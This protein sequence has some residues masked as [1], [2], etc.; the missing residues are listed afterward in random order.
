MPLSPARCACA[1]GLGRGGPVR[2]SEQA[3]HGQAGRAVIHPFSHQ[4]ST[5]TRT[6]AVKRLVKP[7]GP[8]FCAWVRVG[9]RR[10]WYAP[11][12]RLPVRLDRDTQ[13]ALRSARRHRHSSSETFSPS[14]S[15]TFRSQFPDSRFR[16]SAD[17]E[18]DKAHQRSSST[19][20]D[21]AHTHTHAGPSRT[22]PTSTVCYCLRI[23]RSARQA[24]SCHIAR[25]A[26]FVVIP[27]SSFLPSIDTL[28]S[29]FVYA[30][31]NSWPLQSV[32]LPSEG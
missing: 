32:Y 22:S 3:E 20:S 31:A 4:P 19:A 6:P 13:C 16:G 27:S 17:C 30:Y 12:R 26:L 8:P 10:V 24:N 14:L 9:L 1:A 25:H 7:I 11:L 18:A 23:H 29:L 5:P 21:P 2:R 28:Q 15:L